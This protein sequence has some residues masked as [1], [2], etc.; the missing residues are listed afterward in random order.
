[1]MENVL[2]TRQR[3]YHYYSLIKAK[4]DSLKPDNVMNVVNLI[5][6]KQ[7]QLSS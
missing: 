6:A 5:N 2:G 1:M 4:H 7:L 3:G